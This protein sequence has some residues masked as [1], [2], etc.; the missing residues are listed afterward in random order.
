MRAIIALMVMGLMISCGGSGETNEEL[1]AKAKSCPI[2]KKRIEDFEKAEIIE[3]SKDDSRDFYM[4]KPSMWY[5]LPINWK[6]YEAKFMLAYQKCFKEDDA[7]F[8]YI[9]NLYSG[10]R[11]ARYHER[12]GLSE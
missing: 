6:E 2:V 9:R 12:W 3:V 8:I 5:E 4:V 7:D 1:E 10:K 11:I